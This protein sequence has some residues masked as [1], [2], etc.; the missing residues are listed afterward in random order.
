M[1]FEGERRFELV[2]RLDSAQRSNLDDI[3]NLLIPTPAGVQIPL[4]Q[5]ASISIL[6]GPNQ[7]QREDTRR[8]IVVGFNV[9][10]RDVQSIVRELQ[11]KVEQT[12]KLPA[13]YNVRYG[14]AFENLEAAK[15]RLMIAVPVSLLLIFLLLF[16]AFRSVRQGLLIYTAIP[17]SA[18]GGIFLMALREM[19]FSISAG[20]GFIALFGVAVLNGIVLIAEFN[21]LRQSGMTNLHRIVLMGTKVRLRPVLMTAC[22]AS[23]GFLPMAVSNGAGA[24]VQRPLATVVI[25]GL[26]LATFLTL[27]VL[28]VFYVLFE[29]KVAAWTKHGLKAAGMAALVFLLL[30][31]PARAHAQ[32]ISLRAALDTSLKN[33]LGIKRAALTAKY[34]EHLKGGYVSLPQTQF[35]VEAGQINSAYTD[36]RFGMSQSLAFPTVYAA[37]RKVLS[38]EWDAAVLSVTLSKVELRRRVTELFYHHLLLREEERMLLSADSVYADFVQKAALRF[39]KGES[40]IA[41]KSSAEAQRSGIWLQLKSLQNEL[42]LNRIRLQLLLN[43]DVAYEPASET[44]TFVPDFGPDTVDVASHPAVKA[45]EQ[46]LRVAGAVLRLERARLLPDLSIGYYNQSIRG[47]GPDDRVYAATDRF[48]ALQASLGIPIF[49]AAQ[50]ANIRA[51]KTQVSIA[52]AAYQQQSMALQSEWSEAKTSYR[53]SL[54]MVAHIEHSLLPNAQVIIET[55]RRQFIAGEINYLEWTV[56]SNQVFQLRRDYIA[57]LRRLNEAAIKLNYLA[58]HD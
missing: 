38:A 30:L 50:R 20:V 2:V 58:Q 9:R 23:L 56:L 25:G 26:L 21:R 48:H 42:A 7:I 14:G 13:A 10:G 46:Q 51:A 1:V 43:T 16:F 28:P 33:N 29:R 31:H 47:T 17:L 45:Y 37:Q 52:E 5:L 24:E 8:R 19:P 12:L 54:E 27:F 49:T 40:S 18:I 6:N 34:R 11:Q 22:V 57:A 35:S 36:N 41:E 53:S 3:R 15:Q 4:R 39:S 44:L 55:A 32:S